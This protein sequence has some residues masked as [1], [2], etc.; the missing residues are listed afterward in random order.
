MSQTAV[1]VHDA[2]NGLTGSLRV[3]YLRGY[4]R[5]DLSVLMRRFHRQN[6][7]VLISFYRCYTDAFAAGMMHLIGCGKH[8]D[9]GRRGGRHIR[10]SGVLH[11]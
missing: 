1:L 4:E 8:T 3:G 9:D 2:S 11:G 5:S 10:T 6:S 7:N